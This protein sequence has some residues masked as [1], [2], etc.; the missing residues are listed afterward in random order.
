M[1]GNNRVVHFEI[2]TDDPEKSIDFF[3]TVFGWVF[4][5]FGEE[6]YWFA[7]TGEDG[8]QGIDGAIMKKQDPNQPVVNS[9]DVA[10]IEKTSKQ[11]EKAGGKIVVPKSPVPQMGWFCMF[12]DLDGN[13]HGLWQSDE[14]AA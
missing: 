12:T 11:I 13:I 9:I 2:P 5:K 7:K 8:E 3:S 6:D 1:A 4:E 10:D 14:N